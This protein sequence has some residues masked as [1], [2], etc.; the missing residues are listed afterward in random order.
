MNRKIMVTGGYGFIGTNFIRYWLNKYPGD[1]ILNLDCGTYASRPSY[2]DD[3]LIDPRVM[4]NRLRV[5]KHD[6]RWVGADIRDHSVVAKCMQKYRPDHI[7]HF[8]AESHVCRSIAG[9]KAFMQTNAMGTFHLLEEFKNIWQGECDHRFVHVSTDEVFG[10]LS[11]D[12]MD[13][14]NRFDEQWPLK[15]R[16]PYAASKAASDH[17]VQSYHHTYGVETIITNCSNNF[18]PNQH[19]E[20]LIP[21]TILSLLKGERPTIYG[22]GHHVRDWIYVENHCSAIEQVFRN[23]DLG[24]RYCVGGEVE[25]T[26]MEMATMIKEM[27]M[28]T[29][30][31]DGGE[32]ILTNDRPTDDMRYAINPER[33][34]KLGWDSG[35]LSFEE[36]LMSTILWYKDQF[37]RGAL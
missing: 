37:D 3:W 12:P 2:L 30:M 15:P 31:I 27:M 23:G 32:F 5:L 34:K 17:I 19:A 24:Y 22:S 25:M 18:G 33:I 21:K 11:C 1:K 26:N 7:I 4:N 28:A 16:S 9:P 8:A 13:A 14:R 20:K 10:E 29:G 35:K 6:Y 36:N